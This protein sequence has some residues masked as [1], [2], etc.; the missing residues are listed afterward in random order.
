MV[1]Q[2]ILHHYKRFRSHQLETYGNSNIFIDGVD[3]REFVGGGAAYGEHAIAAYLS[4]RR[5]LH[6]MKNL[7][8]SIS[9]I[10]ESE[11]K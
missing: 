7:E 9:P 3:Q 8:A 2:S 11:T 6:F 4:A 10:S 1:N 5:H